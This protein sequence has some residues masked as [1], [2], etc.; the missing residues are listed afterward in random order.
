MRHVHTLCGIKVVSAHCHHAAV[1]NHPAHYPL[2]IVAAAPAW[3][4]I[5]GHVT[6]FGMRRGAAGEPGLVRAGNAATF[7]VAREKEGHDEGTEEN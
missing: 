6:A 2:G 3:L 4:Q 5:R 1:A 7:T